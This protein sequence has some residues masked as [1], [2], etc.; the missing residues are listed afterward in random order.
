[1]Y[2]KTDYNLTFSLK[3]KKKYNTEKSFIIQ[4][5]GQFTCATITRVTI[6][7]SHRREASYQRESKIP[8]LPRFRW[9]G[10]RREKGKG[11][12]I[13]PT[14]HDHCCTL[15]AI[16]YQALVFLAASQVFLHKSNK[17][18]Y[19]SSS[20]NNM[21]DQWIVLDHSNCHETPL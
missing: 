13:S 15:A 12:Q 2:Y 11:K 5:T 17:Y 14:P 1:M 4:K 18:V 7:A 3:K 21:P 20:Q 9:L 10:H 6:T 16:K 19:F 8:Y